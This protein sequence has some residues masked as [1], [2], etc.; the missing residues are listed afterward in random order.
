[1]T[2]K[3]EVREPMNA[4]FLLFF[5]SLKIGVISAATAAVIEKIPEYCRR[6]KFKLTGKTIAII[7]PT[8]SGKNSMFSR[9]ENKP[10]PTEHI[11]TR[12]AEKVTSFDIT[13]PLPNGEHVDFKCKRSV[14]IGGE[15]DE[16][17]RYWLQAC[18]GA[19]VIFYLI[20]AEK[21]RKFETATLKRFHDDMRWLVTNF[22]DLK[23]SVTVHLLL[24]KIDTELGYPPYSASEQDLIKKLVYSIEKEA[25][26][27][28]SEYYNRVTGVNLISMSDKYFFSIYFASTLNQIAE[29]RPK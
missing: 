4:F 26:N 25:R 13:W 28:L 5:Q 17:D 22:R 1:M 3:S 6:I 15:I 21:L 27:T 10:I 7:G 24:N 20:D 18:E 8:A 29:L 11:Q 12:G 2:K 14:N 19:D 16:R 9:L 23:P